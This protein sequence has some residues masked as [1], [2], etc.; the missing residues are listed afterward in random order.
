VTEHQRVARFVAALKAADVIQLGR[1]LAAS[2][3]SLSEDYDVSTPELDTLCDLLTTTPGIY[4]ARLMGGGFGGAALA[5][6]SEQALA[7]D[8]PDVLGTYTAR[9]QL[10][11]ECLDAAAGDG[12]RVFLPDEEPELVQHWLP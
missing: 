11:T 3:H 9:T 5:L 12:A 1:L 7:A 2:H 10:P 4:G 6:L 8:L